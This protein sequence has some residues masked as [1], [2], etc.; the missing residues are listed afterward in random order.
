MMNMRLLGKF[1]ELQK[2]HQACQVCPFYQKN[3]KRMEDARA[4]ENNEQAIAE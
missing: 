1:G 2:Q 3:I 4:I